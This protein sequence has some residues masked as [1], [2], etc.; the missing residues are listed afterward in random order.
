M[1]WEYINKQNLKCK[2]FEVPKIE[3]AFGKTV[4]LFGSISATHFGFKI[5]LLSEILY[6]W[7]AWL[8][9]QQKMFKKELYACLYRTIVF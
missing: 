4:T 2:T 1:S 6:K 3:T 7:K 9:Q 5:K 8:R